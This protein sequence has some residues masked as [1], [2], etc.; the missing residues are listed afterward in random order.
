MHAIVFEI[1][2]PK[3][4]WYNWPSSGSRIISNGCHWIDWFIYLNSFSKVVSY[5]LSTP[6]EHV[7]NLSVTL[8][9]SAVLTLVLTDSGS[10]RYGVREHVEFRRGQSTVSIVDFSR[11]C[12]ESP[13][14]VIRRFRLNPLHAHS[15]MYKNILSY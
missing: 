5:D 7:L 2:L 13:S 3:L 14:A 1:S 4:H 10:P 6:A 12:A 8:E 15:L 11:Y 9:N